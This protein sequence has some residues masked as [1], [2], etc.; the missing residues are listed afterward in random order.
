M[1]ETFRAE[2]D[3]LA[4]PETR[5]LVPA[6]AQSRGTISR[7]RAPSMLRAAAHMRSIVIGKEREN[8]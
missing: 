2:V 3:I 6:G 1:Q 4:T 5:K 7:L 8:G